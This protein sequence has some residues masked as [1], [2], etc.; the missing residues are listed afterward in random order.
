MLTIAE[1]KQ[2]IDTQQRQFLHYNKFREIW[3][4]NKLQ[5]HATASREKIETSSKRKGT[6]SDKSKTIEIALCRL[7]RRELMGVQ[8]VIYNFIQLFWPNTKKNNYPPTIKR[9]AIVCSKFPCDLIEATV[10]SVIFNGQYHHSFEHHLRS[11]ILTAFIGMFRW[12]VAK[13]VQLVLF[14]AFLSAV[15]LICTYSISSLNTERSQIET[16]IM[17]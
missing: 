8:R 12:M 16:S 17:I 13:H 1:I 10:D 4:S 6:R 15:A 11:P 14:F 5:T 2:I 3:A 9:L 7:W